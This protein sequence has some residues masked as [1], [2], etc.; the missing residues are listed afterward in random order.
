[1]PFPDGDLQYNVAPVHQDLQPPKSGTAQ[2]YG[3]N[4][5]EDK[6]VIAWNSLLLKHWADCRYWVSRKLSDKF[7]SEI[8][9]LVGNR[10]TFAVTNSTACLSHRDLQWAMDATGSTGMSTVMDGGRKRMRTEASELP[11]TLSSSPPSRQKSPRDSREPPP[12]PKR[13][14]CTH[15]RQSKVCGFMFQFLPVGQ[16]YVLP[17]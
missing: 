1:M 15:C 4:N 3:D 10:F 16:I 13:V 14:A 11:A 9:A 7:S 8:S 5:S 6:S 17:C 12:Q 2:K